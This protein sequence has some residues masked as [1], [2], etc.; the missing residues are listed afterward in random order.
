MADQG[1]TVQMTFSADPSAVLASLQKMIEQAQKTG[2]AADEV[3][4]KAKGIGKK[5]EEGVDLSISHLMKMAVGFGTMAGA[6]DKALELVMKGLESLV[7]FVPNCIESTAKLT[8]TYKGLHITAGMTAQQFNGYTAAIEMAGGKAEDLTEIVRGMERG[9]KQNSDALVLNGVAASETALRQMS[10]REYV[11]AVVEKME[12]FGSATDKD[13]LLMAA[14]GRG[15]MAFAAQLVEMNEHMAEGIALAEKAAALT[16]KEIEDQKELARVKGELAYEESVAKAR[17]SASTVLVDIAIQRAKAETLRIDNESARAMA[18]T[19]ELLEK[20]LIKLQTKSDEMSNVG[21]ETEDWNAMILEA[22]A[23]DAAI[24]ASVEDTERASEASRKM[25]AEMNKTS[26]VKWRDPVKEAAE[27]EA[28][29]KAAKDAAEVLN[30]LEGSVARIRME[31]LRT[32][33]NQTLE[34]KK[35][36]AFQE[37]A[38]KLEE[39]RRRID[40]E[41]AKSPTKGNKAAGAQAKAAAEKLYMDQMAQ[42]QAAFDRDQ[43]AAEKSIQEFLFQAEEVGLQKRLD[44]LH[45]A[46]AAQREAESKASSQRFTAAQF[47]AAEALAVQRETD[48]FTEE[49]MRKLQEGLKALAKEKGRALS[50]GEQ[51]EELQHLAVKLGLTAESVERVRAEILQAKDALGGAK[52][53]L[54][55]FVA[56]SQ[57]DWRLWEHG[58][59]DAARGASSS[60]ASAMSSMIMEHKTFTEAA[61]SA[62][63]SFAAD[64]IRNL[65]DIE[66]KKATGWALDKARSAWTKADTATDIV[67]QHTKG[68]ATVAAATESAEA[69]ETEASSADSATGSN[70]SQAASAFFASFADIPWYGYALAVAAI[71]GMMAVVKSV[72]AH[73]VGGVID[74]PTLA[75][76]GEAGTEIVAPETDFRHYSA[77]LVNM[78]ATLAAAHAAQN[79]QSSRYDAL[80]TSYGRQAAQR[81]KEAPRGDHYHMEGALI[82]SE[83]LEGKRV[84]DRHLNESDQ[85]RGRLSG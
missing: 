68:A 30:S 65:A 5:T 79:A 81:A 38:A 37:A 13:T 66:A 56:E 46:F 24:K 7:E 62:W 39:E 14:F 51:I 15:G 27:K 80:G 50:F 58:A 41:V 26:A 1:Y 71:A 33:E 18:R 78:G 45:A 31:D 34:S 32:Q 23:Y 47:D 2:T 4:N 28:R 19:Q 48:R 70:L 76:M 72:T 40:E 84:L 67:L 83:S 54:T 29:D 49:G 82:V 57:D 25:I 21:A 59:Q 52:A 8:E 74:H 42:A 9:I 77:N 36:L 16:E 69:N 44:N 20:G 12:K 6:A 75:L 43:L 53:G 35:Q 10:L 60:M 3:G 17:V 73:A 64:V 85:R 61:R 22:R 11:A 55:N 63:K